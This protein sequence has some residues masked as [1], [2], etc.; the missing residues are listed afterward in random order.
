MTLIIYNKPSYVTETNF[1]V[2]TS[3]RGCRLLSCGFY[4]GDD[5]G[6]LAI[7]PFVDEGWRGEFLTG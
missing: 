7:T 5:I 2:T 6:S 4:S 3:S 1:I